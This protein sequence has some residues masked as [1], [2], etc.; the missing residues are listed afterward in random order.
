MKNLGLSERVQQSKD[1]TGNQNS[2]Y[3][4][5]GASNHTKSERHRY[6]YY[7]TEPKAMEL[8]LEEE[9]FAP[10]VWECACGE[11]H[12]ARVLEKAGYEVVA[13]D[14]IYRGY[15]NTR[16]VD[17]LK[18]TLEGFD[19]DIITN[20]PYKF[21]LEFVQRALESVRQGRKVAMFLKL[22]F[23]EGRARKQFFK[24]NPP[25]VVYVSSSRLLCAMNGEFGKIQ[26]SAVA[27][28]W[29]VWEKGFQGDPIIKWIN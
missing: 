24:K 27:Y 17:F 7:A 15:G 9:Q 28:A 5:L 21:A 22:Q 11:G 16:P 2:I 6:D 23:L 20:P 1:W 4:T 25:K 18:E 10:V 19:G 3:K 29:F 12:L 26:S 13:T 14:L 8:L